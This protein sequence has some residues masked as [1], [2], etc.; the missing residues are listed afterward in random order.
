MDEEE[1]IAQFGLLLTQLRFTRRA[2]ENIE[3]NTARY[4]SFNFAQLFEKGKKFIE[5]PMIN[6]A[7][8]VHIVN[9]NDLAPGGGGLIEGLLGGIGRLFGGFIGGIVGGTASMVTLPLMLDQAKA[10]TENFLKIMRI[11]SPIMPNK[12]TPE[13]KKKGAAATDKAATDKA[14]KG[15]AVK[16][17]KQ[18]SFFEVFVKS[19]PRLTKAANTLT[20]LFNAASSGPGTTPARAKGRPVEEK[21]QVRTGNKILDILEAIYRVLGRASHLVNGLIILLPILIGAFALL[22]ARLDTIKLAV[23]EMLMFAMR[24]VF[25]L[26]GAILVTLFDTASS[27]ATLAARILSILAETV[28]KLIGAAFTLINSMLKAALAA[29]AFVADGVKAVIDKLVPWIIDTVGKALLFIGDTSV[30]RYTAHLVRILPYILPALVKLIRDRSLT[31]DEMKLIKKAE[32]VKVPGALFPGGKTA[33]TL[34]PFPDLKKALVPEAGTKTLLDAVTEAGE[35]LQKKSGTILGSS[36]EALKKIADTLNTKVFDKNYD[37]L[38]G[39]VRGQASSLARTLEPAAEKLRRS[40]EA[41]KDKPLTGLPA[42]AQAYEKWLTEKGGL[43]ALIDRINAHFRYTTQPGPESLKT[44][45]GRAVLEA[46]GQIPLATIEIDR[47]TVLVKE[48]AKTTPPVQQDGQE[49]TDSLYERIMMEA[50]KK[51]ERGGDIYDDDDN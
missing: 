29:F 21:E 31:T 39:Q 20:A 17:E 4:T 15:K 3:R 49:D 45:Q 16:K 37:A 46:S 33:V 32:T 14:V 5:P 48:P 7:L 43:D 1:F 18:P 34:E 27:A 28:Q 11:F 42:I 47:I 12:K 24:N 30:F 2:V 36:E 40:E 26:R 6:G 41:Q 35:A 22:L 19:L 8:K 23:L 51:K 44:I 10:I 50:Y 13:N 38:L 25:L 9:I